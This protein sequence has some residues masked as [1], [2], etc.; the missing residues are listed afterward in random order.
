MMKQG[1]Q[2]YFK[3]AMRQHDRFC[4]AVWNEAPGVNFC[5]PISNYLSV[6][7]HGW[8]HAGNLL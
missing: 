8:L 7:Q 3:L 2:I 4:P 5:K 1:D 6:G